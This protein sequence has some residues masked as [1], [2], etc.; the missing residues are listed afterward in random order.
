MIS[1]F[2]QLINKN[3]SDF[4]YDCSIEEEIVCFTYGIS[5]GRTNSESTISRK[6]SVLH[7]DFPSIEYIINNDKT[8]F[9]INDFIVKNNIDYY[10]IYSKNEDI[11]L[12]KKFLSDAYKVLKKMWS[13]DE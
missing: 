8:E 9:S 1:I 12:P 6:I 7:I 13:D 10:V 4:I 3:G 11:L 5:H 2:S